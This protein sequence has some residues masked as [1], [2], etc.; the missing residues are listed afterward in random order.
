[1]GGQ[2]WQSADHA[3]GCAPP[4]WC[5]VALP[6][7][8][9]LLGLQGQHAPLRGLACR[10][11]PHLERSV[12]RP[13]RQKP[14]QCSRTGVSLPARYEAWYARELPDFRLTDLISVEYAV[15]ALPC[16]REQLRCVLR[17]EGPHKPLNLA[18]KR[19]PRIMSRCP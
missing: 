7:D 13:P 15:D 9:Q 14:E 10:S 18:H 3:G 8:P 5:L 11:L 4:G 17:Q 19:A 6:C 16:E 1:M 12:Q 2:H